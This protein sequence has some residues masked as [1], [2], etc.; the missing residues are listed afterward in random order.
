M[1][2]ID[3]RLVAEGI[4]AAG[5]GLVYDQVSRR[6]GGNGLIGYAVPVAAFI[7]GAL[8]A[9]QSGMMGQLAKGLQHGGSASLGYT[10]TRKLV[11]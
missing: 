1:A 8:M 7:G 4:S 2:M 9:G 3:G 10:L 6:M 5:V 11:R